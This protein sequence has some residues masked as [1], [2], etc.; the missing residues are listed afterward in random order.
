MFN[1][2]LNCVSCMN[3]NY[4]GSVKFCNNKIIFKVCERSL[5]DFTYNFIYDEIW[6]NYT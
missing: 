1:I 2:D 4:H 3:Y 6:I 5:I